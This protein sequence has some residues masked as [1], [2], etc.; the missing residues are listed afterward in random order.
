MAGVPDA[1]KLELAIGEA[2]DAVA[3]LN[4]SLQTPP[5]GTRQPSDIV[6]IIDI[7]GSMGME[8]TI[9][10]ASGTAESH[11]L[12][13][14]DVAKHGVRTIANAL[15]PQDRLSVVTFNHTSEV[16]F[17]LREMDEAGKTFAEEKLEPMMPGGG[18]N[19]W[20]GLKNGLNTLVTGAAPGRFGHVMLLT[21]G[22]SQGRESI[23][24]NLMKFKAEKEG[25]PGSINTF[26][27]GYNLDSK[28]LV[29]LAS[30]G[31]GSYS[32]IP[33][34]GFVGTAF[35]N[36]MSQLLVTMAQE[37]YVTVEKP[38]GGLEL[39]TPV[40]MAGWSVEDKGDFYSISLGSLQFGQS[41]D[42]VVPIKLASAD[43]A[44]DI[45]IGASYKTSGG[46]TVELEHGMA[47]VP[48][49][50]GAEANLKVEEQ[51]C[52]CVF[53]EALTK[54]LDSMAVN[55]SEEALKGCLTMLTEKA[56][57]IQASPGAGTDVVKALLEDVLGQSTEAV[58]RHDWYWRWGVHYLPSVL[59]AHKLQICN[60]FKDPGVQVYGGELFQSIREEADEIFCKIPAPKPTARRSYGGGYSAAPSAPVSMAAY[61][62]SSAV[63]VDGTCWAELANGERRRVAELAKGDRLRGREGE[64]AE[65]VC[66][67]RTACEGGRARLVELEG[68]L[69]LTPYH[70]VLAGG[71]WR[72]PAELAEAKELPC[73]AVYSFVVRG[74]PAVA[75]AGVACA[76]LGHGL[77][78]GALA[79]PYFAGERVLEDVAGYAGFKDGLVEL[80]RG[81]LLRDPETGLIC[82]LAGAQ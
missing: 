71:A 38:E 31:M 45:A 3:K 49:D 18:T 41:K 50:A 55:R 63:C 75:V 21:D 81:A 60:N 11:G 25:L 54:T 36:M 56:A 70:P 61:H 76:A 43:A 28:L 4:V 1:A 59:F 53:V 77:S 42:V 9:A 15:G 74:A 27:F 44:G 40:V 48:G 13:L 47:K 23:V 37:V 73:E 20:E 7:S 26:G 12:S 67:V 66:L 68:G 51:W 5:G 62:D 29:E 33:D 2:K 52:R 24:P 69:R 30:A 14:L 10:G 19:I 78:E 16:I 65:L 57:A 22:E 82:S 64:E 72:F 46:K 34:A 39:Q 17:P 80:P 79:H 35:V 58:S 6:C 8:A 32:F